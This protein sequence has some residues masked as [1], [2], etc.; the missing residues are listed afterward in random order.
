MI[1]YQIV[2]PRKKKQVSIDIH[3]QRKDY[4]IPL[5]DVHKLCKQH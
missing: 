3:L 1:T 2:I 4:I 5:K